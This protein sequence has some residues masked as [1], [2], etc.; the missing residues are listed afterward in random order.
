M[1]QSESAEAW[2]KR[3]LDIDSSDP[4]EIIF[5]GMVKREEELDSIGEYN[6]SKSQNLDEPMLGVHDMYGYDEV[7]VRTAD[8]LGIVGAA[9]DQ[10]RIANN[11]DTTYGRLGSVMSGPAMKFALEGVEEFES[12]FTGLA[13]SLSDAG[14][15]GYR[16][17]DGKMINSVTIRESAEEL[18][19]SMNYMTDAEFAKT[20]DSFQTGINPDTGAP[21]MSS[22]GMTA[23]KL[24]IKET[25]AAYA[26]QNSA[27]AAALVRTS[28]AGQVS[29]LAEGY[30]LSPGSAAQLRTSEQILDRLQMLYIANGQVGKERGFLLN[31]MNVFKR[32]K[33]MTAADL[34]KQRADTTKQLMAE[35]QATRE[36]LQEIVENKPEYL[37]PFMM[38]YEYTDGNVKLIDDLQTYL[39]NS[40]GVISKSFYDGHPEIPS[41]VM[42]GFWQTMYNNVLSALKTP[43]KAGFSSA[44]LLV[45]RPINTFIGTIGQPGMRQQL[46]RGWFQYTAFA[47]SIQKGAKYFAETMRRN[48][49]DPYYSG[50][51]GRDD[52]ITKNEQQMDILRAF[53]NGKAEVGEMGP[54]ALV[55]QID[56]IYALA[57]HPWMRMG[58]RLMQATDGFTQAVIANVEARGKAFDMINLNKNI[59]ANAMESVAKSQYEAMWKMD[60][61]GRPIIKDEM[62]RYAAGEIAMNL[63]NDATRLF[64]ELINRLP[65][66]KP[67]LLFTKTPINLLGSMFSRV[68]SPLGLFIKDL[69]KFDRPF[70]E[71]PGPEMERILGSRGIPYDD[72]AQVRYESIRAEMRGRKA[73][74]TMAV[75]LAAGLW[76]SDSITGNGSADRQV[77]KVRTDASLPKKS[78]KFPNG[79]WVSYEP[80]GPL[81][82]WI[83]LTV[84]IMDNFD[85]LGESK[86]S[87]LMSAVG[88]ALTAA[89]TDRSMLPALEPLYDMMS[90]NKGAINRFAGAFITS[91]VIPGSSL[92]AEFGRALVPGLRV[93]EEQL[94]AHIINRTPLK[95]T[96]PQQY[97]WVTGKPAKGNNNLMRIN[98]TYNPFTI[99]AEIEPEEQFLI[100]VEYDS[101]PTMKTDGGVELTIEEQAQVL[102]LIGQQG[103]FQKKLRYIMKNK[104]AAEFRRKYQ[105]AQSENA[106]PNKDT[107]D[108][109]HIEIDAALADAKKAAIAEIDAQNMK[110]GRPTIRDRK[111]DKEQH[112]DA[113]RRGNV[114]YMKEIL[115]KTQTR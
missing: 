53:A 112:K 38:A 57:N 59:D 93:V 18:A 30:R 70:M 71:V 95:A 27:Q 54:Q 34:R 82:D 114:E 67:F 5:K 80:L 88:F 47:D 66:L 106:M 68:P 33:K 81:G 111:S 92:Q 28:L 90:G 2:F 43:I 97:S 52:L 63:D 10:V 75:T 108:N 48:G 41:V 46:R 99:S 109:L 14:E 37:A 29:D 104:P 84:D 85:T 78:I 113:S 4:E 8:N 105:Q 22:E 31:L 13:K 62:V 101:R 3:N 26:E 87:Q 98:N 76:M 65:A 19:R 115:D 24:Q 100:D 25:H 40:I 58:T 7:G 94:G 51:P 9:V 11:Y 56:Q 103:I 86:T 42:Q 20:L 91:T 77:N 96:L 107:F 110:A 12:V 32:G 64:S 69:Q 102:Q 89:V 6:F 45:E 23:V 83:A 73:T 36:T 21:M 50:V 55:E 60:K 44:A 79:G 72:F 49:L 61:K 16:L 35:A 17:L 1:P 15:Y 39:D 74:G